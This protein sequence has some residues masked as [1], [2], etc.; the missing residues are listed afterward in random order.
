ME[1]RRLDE[2]Q[3]HY[4]ATGIERE[5]TLRSDFPEPASEL[6]EG[7]VWLREDV[8]A[9]INEHGEAVA[10]ILKHA[11]MPRPPEVRG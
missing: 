5:L 9:W 8:E 3:V 10:D 2:L 4:P 11:S 1:S 7:D 6:A